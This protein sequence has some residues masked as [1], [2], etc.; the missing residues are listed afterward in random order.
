MSCVTNRISSRNG[1][2]A[3]ANGV[4]DFSFDLLSTKYDG[5][6]RFTTETAALA[7]TL[8]AG[9]RR[10]R[11][12]YI[13]SLAGQIK[14]GEWQQDH[15]APILFSDALRVIDGQHR[16]EAIVLSGQTVIAR[17][18]FGVRDELREYLDTGITRRLEDRCEFSADDLLLNKFISQV[19]Q[20]LW[21]ITGPMNI[22]KPSPAEAWSLFNS[23]K[24]AILFA[25]SYMRRNQRGISRAPVMAALTEFYERSPEGADEFARTLFVAD[26]EKQQA[27]MLRDWLLQ[28]A[29]RGGGSGITREVYDKSV[30]CMR[31]AIENR[32]IT[33]VRAAAWQ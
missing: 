32:R 2:I 15:P 28:R 22:K 31:A 26:G 16:L 10:K 33:A 24:D 7:L 8:N 9:N 29:P 27:R 21:Y 18:C 4:V 13:V 25:A 3:A 11:P 6:C 20:S 5:K 17:V 1:A 14:D 30:G 19:V 23:K 12:H